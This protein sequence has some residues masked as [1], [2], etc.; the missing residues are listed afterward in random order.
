MA[1]GQERAR[2]PAPRLLLR[3]TTAALVLSLLALVALAA[4]YW[5]SLE[6]VTAETA[7]RVE[8]NGRLRNLQ[9]LVGA[10]SEAESGQR[11]YLLTRRDVYLAQHADAV[12]RIP[13][14]LRAL[15][16]IP[17]DDARLP[18]HAAAAQEAIR[19]KLAELRQTIELVS[20]G[21][22]ER[23]FQVVLTDEGR[24]H[25]AR[26]AS[27]IDAVSR[28][29]LADRD[30]TNARLERD[31][32]INRALL[33]TFVGTLVVS[34][35]LTA[36]QLISLR[37]SERRYE[38]ELARSEERHRAI[39]EEQ[40]ELISLAQVDGT[41]TYVNPA[42]CR[43][44]GLSADELVGRS[45]YEGV[46]PEDIEQVR[47]HVRA[48]L[49]TGRPIHS[50]NRIPG[51][52]GSARWFAWTNS[53]RAGPANQ[54]LLHSVG[55]DVTERKLAEE[56][57][58]RSAH[59]L[60]L[61]TGSLR[62]VIESIPAI[63]A[64]LDTECR[65]RMV[66]RS[67]ERWRGRSRGEVIGRSVLEVF[68]PAEHAASWPWAQ[69]ALAGET[70]TFEKEY[71]DA[72]SRVLRFTYMPMLLVDGTVGGLIGEA[73][74]ITLQRSEEQRLISLSEHDALTGLLN[75]AGLS[76]HLE[77]ALRAGSGKTLALMFVDLDYFKPVNDTYG[78]AVG[79]ELLCR[80]A[81]RLEGLVRPTDLVARVGGDE[82][83]IVLLGMPDR[84][85]VE[86]VAD[87][88]VRAC[89][90]PFEFDAKALR[91]GACVGIALGTADG[92]WRDLLRRADE[93]AYAAKASGRGKYA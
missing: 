44:Y 88:V 10:V 61:Q 76:R 93:A 84:S 6:V 72:S 5:R 69:R 64:V 32:R 25:A 77:D 58:H 26:A 11:G 17:V 18:G 85:S 35:A 34:A 12:A 3:L 27:E 15:D 8:F 36:V 81:R 66:N 73:H 40:V 78:H 49:D 7:R 51:S 28:I 59:E 20:A 62:A 41:L 43:Q 24:R 55:R 50:E 42:Y 70:V 39:V 56:A 30:R 2:F 90:M 31:G 80:V 22:S 37:R 71:A 53:V 54:P 14:L 79:D 83:S 67:W 21:E 86:A 91:I 74:D 29:V 47:S 89:A 38:A 23:A 68:G 82:F 65:Y 75:R 9:A 1:K 52:D 60:E 63:V 48:A 16:G 87:K 19:R 13:A 33:V 4:V 46:L 45:L 92:D 57:L